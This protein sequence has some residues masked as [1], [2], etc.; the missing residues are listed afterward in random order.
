M[1]LQSQKQGPPSLAIPLI[2][3]NEGKPENGILDEYL[4]ASPNI[5]AWNEAELVKLFL[6]GIPS[7]TNKHEYLANGKRI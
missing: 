7:M 4:W 5:G 2:D 1:N 3:F 6:P